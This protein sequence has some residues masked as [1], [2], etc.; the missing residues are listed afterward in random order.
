MGVK[1]KPKSILAP[2]ERKIQDLKEGC[3]DAIIS[4]V[5]VET[6][7]GSEHFA[8]TSEDQINLQNLT[9]QLA[10]GSEVVLYHADGKLCRPFSA[11]EI[12]AVAEA[13][14]RHVTYHTT[15]FNHLKTWVAR[16]KELSALQEITYGA[17]L[18]KDLAEHMSALLDGGEA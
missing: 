4:G 5:D 7:A 15:Y 14:V 10:A 16:T 6:S 11:L 2:H 9:F 17:Q 13:A 1:F 3:T 8:L 12:G 18:P